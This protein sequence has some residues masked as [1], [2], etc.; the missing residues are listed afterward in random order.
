MEVADL[1]NRIPGTE[2]L[3]HRAEIVGKVG[4]VED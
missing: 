4:L 1:H 2:G 3:K